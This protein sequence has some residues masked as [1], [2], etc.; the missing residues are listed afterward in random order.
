M[1]GDFIKAVLLAEAGL[2]YK[3]NEQRLYILNLSAQVF[4]I[5]K[6][7]LSEHLCGP[8]N[9]SIK[10]LNFTVMSESKFSL[11][12]FFTVQLYLACISIASGSGQVEKFWISSLVVFANC[13]SRMWPEKGLTH[14][15]ILLYN[16][17]TTLNLL[18]VSGPLSYA[19]SQAMMTAAGREKCTA[20]VMLLTNHHTFPSIASCTHLCCITH[21]H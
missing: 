18:T 19:H 10:D 14:A 20:K 11:L 8:H 2:N 12:Q 5:Y 9:F 16:R 6:I 3:T 21:H 17:C 4:S 7:F 15:E 13:F 1:C